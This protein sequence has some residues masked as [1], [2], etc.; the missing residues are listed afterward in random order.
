MRSQAGEKLID[1]SDG[2]AIEFASIGGAA[3]QRFHRS[4]SNTSVSLLLKLG[5][6]RHGG[7]LPGSQA[8]HGGCRWRCG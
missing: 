5:I 4:R 1:Q 2:L 7:R 3:G 6:D 8:H